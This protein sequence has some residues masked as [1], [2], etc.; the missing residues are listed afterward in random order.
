MHSEKLNDRLQLIG[1]AGIIAS[2][3]FVGIQ[4]IQSQNI[5]NADRFHE[6]ISSNVAI[7][8]SIIENAPIFT[9]ANNGE[10]LNETE[11]LILTQ[12]LDSFWGLAFFGQQAS[13]LVGGVSVE[14]PSV[15]LAMFLFENPGVRKEWTEIQEKRQQ[16]WDVLFRP[17]SPLHQFNQRVN[18][19]L[20]TL[21]EHIE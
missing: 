8:D 11:I 17:N 18:E 4:L 19:H 6:A 1:M 3:I 21:D 5:A 12:T 9:K 10:E 14:G 15:G 13:E 20:A 7:N 2:L 16:G